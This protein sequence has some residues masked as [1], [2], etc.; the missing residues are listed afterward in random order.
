M[1]LRYAS[2]LDSISAARSWASSREYPSGAAA[3]TSRYRC[4]LLETARM[5]PLWQIDFQIC[6]GCAAESLVDR[7]IMVRC[8]QIQVSISSA[9]PSGSFAVNRTARLVLILSV[10]FG[11]P[12]SSTHNAAIVHVVPMLVGAD[13][14]GGFRKRWPEI[15]LVWGLRGSYA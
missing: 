13:T 10:R 14:P 6:G 7:I 9:G 15:S 2:E 1:A 12:P 4:V 5:H 3:E 11:M 8:V